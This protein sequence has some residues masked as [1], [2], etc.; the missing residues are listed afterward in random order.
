LRS[1]SHC[2]LF[3]ISKL[4]LLI[5]SIIRGYDISKIFLRQLLDGQYECLDGQ[6]RLRAILGYLE[7]KFS[8]SDKVT[9]EV[10]NKKFSQIEE[11]LKWRIKSFII[12]ATLVHNID[13][14]TTCQIFL[15]LQEGMPLNA[16]EKLNAM[17]GEVRNK[18]VELSQHKFFK[19][20]GIK[21]YRFS[22][23]YICAQI[24]LLETRGNIVDTKFKNLKE[25]YKTSLSFVK[26]DQVASILNSLEKEI[27][28]DAKLIKQNADFVSLFM[29]G[30]YLLKNYALTDSRGKIKDFF[31]EFLITV[32]EIKSAESESDLAF[33][34]IKHIVDST[35]KCNKIRIPRKVYYR[36]GFF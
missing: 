14:E 28:D 16:P 19:K 32:G 8:L 13:D 35:L 22:H 36:Q 15:R 6:Q 24:L 9:P 33:G 11:E 23:R 26:F 34:T 7:D 21:D 1:T 17:K 3:G 25:M 12:Y 10:G 5:D 30:S 29:L 20:L 27:D 2:A 31:K 4:K 18:I